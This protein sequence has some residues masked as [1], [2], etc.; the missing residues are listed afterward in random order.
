[1]P[2]FTTDMKQISMIKKLKIYNKRIS[3]FMV[4]ELLNY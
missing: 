4:N 2:A 3:G 1:M